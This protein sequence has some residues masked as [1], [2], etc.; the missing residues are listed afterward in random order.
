MFPES[1]TAALKVAIK[2]CVHLTST[3]ITTMIMVFLIFPWF[4]TLHGVPKLLVATIAPLIFL[5]SKL[6]GRL[7][8]FRL[9]GVLHP[10]TSYALVSMICA[11][12]SVMARVMQADMRG[13]K[14]FVTCG[15]LHGVVHVLETLV[16]T[17]MDRWSKM[18]RWLCSNKKGYTVN[19][20]VFSLLQYTNNLNC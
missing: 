16:F 5:P 10:S 17:T 11:F 13:F 19:T 4:L 9:Q 15:M 20:L 6:L 8:V 18:I 14:M 3:L 1:R 12:E 7:C 2:L